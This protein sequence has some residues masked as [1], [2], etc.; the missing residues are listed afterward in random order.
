MGQFF[1][2]K[3]KVSLSSPPPP[4]STKRIRL[5]GILVT[6][7]EPDD[8]SGL[9]FLIPGALL[10]EASYISTRQVLHHEQNQVVISFYV[11]VFA[12]SHD[13][14]ANDVTRIY[15][16]Y[17]C[18]RQRDSS[19]SFD[20]K[21]YSIVGHSVGGKIAL[22]CVTTT[23]NPTIESGNNVR[24]NKNHMISTVLALDPVDDRPPE[25]TNETA[26]EKNRMLSKHLATRVVL[27]H[28]TATRAG[29]IPIVHNAAAIAATAPHQ[30]RL[31]NHPDAA[32]MAYT[33]NNGGPMGWMMRGG[34]Q[35]GNQAAREDAQALI[36][37]Y[38]R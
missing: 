14:F 38:I 30:V 7:S 8:P 15:Q 11:N 2:K 19:K 29:A 25:F 5:G 13:A 26:K 10:S 16:A 9:T 32:H 34:T 3:K 22:L 18:Q 33:D 36:R 37:Q 27:T 4:L 6:L 20:P 23:T 28:A 24:T 21:G 17:C 31:V 12:K 1:S 35:Q